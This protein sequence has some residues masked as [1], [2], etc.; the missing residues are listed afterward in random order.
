MPPPIPDDYDKC[1][2]RAEMPNRYEM[3]EVEQL[4]TEA[5]VK[6][7]EIPAIY[8]MVEEVVLIKE[9]SVEWITIPAVYEIINEQV[10]V[11]EESKVLSEQYEEV[12]EEILLEEEKGKWVQELDPNCT[13]PN[14]EDC[15]IMHWEKIPA[16]YK[17]ETQKILKKLGG[18]YDRVLP[19]EYKMVTKRVM[20]TPPRIEERII[21]AIYDTLI[22][23]VLVEPAKTE[24]ILVKNKLKYYRV[25]NT[26]MIKTLNCS[27]F[28]NLTTLLHGPI[29]LINSND[30]KLISKILKAK[31]RVASF[32]VLFLVLT[33]T[34]IFLM[35]SIRFAQNSHLPAIVDRKGLL[36]VRRGQIRLRKSLRR[37]DLM[38]EDQTFLPRS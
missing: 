20:V 38:P 19:P 26:L 29:I 33:S 7:L 12:T 24:Q 8:K 35:L 11:K 17:T 25:F 10:L 13:S 21:P 32:K 30:T 31:A 18:R 9:A 22:K 34:T 28:K 23:Q 27:I 2:G 1:Y 4:V 36:L 37:V 5:Y 3:A 6:T 16:K 15:I 14:S